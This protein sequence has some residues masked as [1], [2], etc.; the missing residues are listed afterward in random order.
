MLVVISI[1]STCYCLLYSLHCA[2]CTHISVVLC[3]CIGVFMIVGRIPTCLAA[4]IKFK[5]E[6]ESA[7]SSG[8][9]TAVCH[10]QCII[11]YVNIR[12]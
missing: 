1:H 7:V 11:V 9:V 3:T 6:I 8:K 2:N 12:R 5:S 10:E 4:D